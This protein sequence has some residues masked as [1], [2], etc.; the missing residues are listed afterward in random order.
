[1]ISNDTRKEELK[2]ALPEDFW[3]YLD[4][5]DALEGFLNNTIATDMMTAED[6][7]GKVL[8]DLEDIPF[9]VFLGAFIWKHTPEQSD[10]WADLDEGWRNIC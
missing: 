2:Q 1:M 7:V 4:E 3:S 8:E 9:D 6:V 10:F 5:N